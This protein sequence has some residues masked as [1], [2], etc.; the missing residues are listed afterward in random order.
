MLCLFD[1]AIFDYVSVFVTRR[2]LGEQ[3]CLDE[4]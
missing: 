4:H 3:H 2:I 1:Q